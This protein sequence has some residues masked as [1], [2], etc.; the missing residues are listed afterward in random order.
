M[1]LAKAND[2]E[3]TAIS[4]LTIYLISHIQHA[5]FT[6]SM[7]DLLFSIVDIHMFFLDQL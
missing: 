3:L 2:F 6:A 5:A 4:R 1:M 7:T